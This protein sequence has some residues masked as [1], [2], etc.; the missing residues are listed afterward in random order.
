MNYADDELIL[1]WNRLPKSEQRY[2]LGTMIE[3]MYTHDF[4]LS[5][6]KQYEA[7]KPFT[8]RQLAVIRKWSDD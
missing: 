3:K 6:S 1:W 7:E 5:L 2:I 4:A 8:P